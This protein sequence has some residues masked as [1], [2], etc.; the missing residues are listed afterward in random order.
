VTKLGE[1]DK[2]SVLAALRERLQHDLAAAAESQQRTQSGATHEESRPENE[3]DTRALESSYLAR[4]QAQRVIELSSA[5]ASLS[6]LSLREFDSTAAVLL[7]ALV[8]LEDG[9]GTQLYFLAPVGGG[10]TLSLEGVSVR[11]ITPESP[12]GRALIGRRVN[13]DIEVPTPQGLREYSI[14]A[15]A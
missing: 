13:D 10:L 7:S 1:I 8:T 15:L 11:V 14:T 3:K 9:K 2:A 4:G 5:L 6:G 12:L